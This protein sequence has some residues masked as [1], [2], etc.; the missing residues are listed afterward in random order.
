M[1]SLKNFVYFDDRSRFLKKNQQRLYY[2]IHVKSTKHD[3]GSTKVF[4]K[5]PFAN[6]KQ[7]NNKNSLT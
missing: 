7:K 3:C 5:V 2:K 4:K 1:L 6:T